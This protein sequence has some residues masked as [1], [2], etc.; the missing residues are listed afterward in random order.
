MSTEE[1]FTKIENGTRDLI[2]V[3]R[4]VL[5]AIQ[6]LEEAQRHTDGAINALIQ[7]QVETERKVSSLADTVDKLVRL[8][9]PNGQPG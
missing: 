8:R 3:S 9:G 7:A 2:M 6:K 1:R 4:T 5:T